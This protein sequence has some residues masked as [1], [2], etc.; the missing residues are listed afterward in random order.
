M[1]APLQHNAA[2]ALREHI[3][4]LEETILQ[5]REQLVPSVTFPAEIGLTAT[6]NRMLSFLLAGC[7]TGRS[8]VAGRQIHFERRLK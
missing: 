8:A 4:E 2:A 1:N 6:E 5:L 3:E 7:Q